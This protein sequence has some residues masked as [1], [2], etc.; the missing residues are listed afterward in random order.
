MDI[1]TIGNDKYGETLYRVYIAT[2]TAWYKVFQVYAYNESEAVD[3]VADHCEENE[4]EG[5]YTDFYGIADECEV[6]QS[7][8]EYVEAHN[9]ICCGNHG[10]YI[11]IAGIECLSK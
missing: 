1:T 10:I 6:G 11:E 7:V 3:M 4:F 9:L 5:L 8:D 2:G